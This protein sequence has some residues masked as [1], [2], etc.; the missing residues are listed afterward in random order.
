MI[1]DAEIEARVEAMATA[2]DCF[3][4][5]DVTYLTGMGREALVRM[6]NAGKGPPAVIAGNALLYPI[7]AFKEWLA[8]NIGNPNPKSRKKASTGGAP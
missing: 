1:T 4:A 8:T 6:R 5:R 2:L 7:P 3:T